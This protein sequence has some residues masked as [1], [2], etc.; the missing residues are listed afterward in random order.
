MAASALRLNNA[1]SSFWYIFV[2]AVLLGVIFYGYNSGGFVADRIKGII[3]PLMKL[4]GAI[5]NFIFGI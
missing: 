4:G 1:M 2:P 5:L 3:D